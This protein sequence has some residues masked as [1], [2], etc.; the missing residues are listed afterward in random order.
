MFGS[1]YETDPEGDIDSDPRDPD[2]VYFSST[3]GSGLDH[4]VSLEQ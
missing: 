1:Y 4:S 3:D 2:I